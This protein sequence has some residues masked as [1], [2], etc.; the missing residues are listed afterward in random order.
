MLQVKSEEVE[1]GADFGNA[2]VK[3]TANG[4]RVIIFPHAVYEVPGYEW[5][6]IQKQSG[7]QG[8]HPDYVAIYDGVRDK[9]GS[10]YCTG[11]TALQN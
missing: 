9:V 1:L 5:A 8:A 3:L 7:D 2:Q 10:V 4:K 6:L 11:A